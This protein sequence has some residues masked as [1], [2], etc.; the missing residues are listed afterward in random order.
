MKFNVLTRIEDFKNP[1]NPPE[2]AKP[3]QIFYALGSVDPL[4]KWR[5]GGGLVGYNTIQ[6]PLDFRSVWPS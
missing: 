3:R 6:E 1:F 4:E 5:S 2:A